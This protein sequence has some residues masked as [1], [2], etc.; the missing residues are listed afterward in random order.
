MRENKRK[1]GYPFSYGD[2][3][4]PEM[5][6]ENIAKYD[7]RVDDGSILENLQVLRKFKHVTDFKILGNPNQRIMNYLKIK[8]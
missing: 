4:I 1:L 6:R 7:R 5:A 8:L 2:E 3:L